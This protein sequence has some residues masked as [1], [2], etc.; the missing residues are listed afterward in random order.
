MKS[1]VADVWF[2]RCFLFFLKFSL[3]LLGCLP[4]WGF[5]VFGILLPELGFAV[6]NVIIIKVI[7]SYFPASKSSVSSNSDSLIPWLD[8][9][10][11]VHRRC[12]LVFHN[13]FEKLAAIHKEVDVK[14]LKAADEKAAASSSLS[15]WNEV[16][17]LGNLDKF[18]KA[19]WVNESV[20]C[21]LSKTVSSSRYV[22]L[23]LDGTVKLEACKRE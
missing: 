15:P 18:H 17:R 23:L 4:C 11:N 14:F 21:L 8:V 9:F 2:Y 7:T 1:F 19:P 13:L 16:Y 3:S 5:Q 6:W 12:S 20:S 10:G 22:S